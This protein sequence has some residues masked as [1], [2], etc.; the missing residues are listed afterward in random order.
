MKKTLIAAAILSGFAG[1][2]MAQNVTI[3]GI[4]DASVVRID[5]GTDS[6]IRLDSGRNAAS[7]L[8]FRGSED[9]GGGLKATFNLEHGFNVDNGSMAT[10]NT[11]F[12]R[13][14]WVGLEGGF[15]AV[16]AGR[17]DSPFRT[18]LN[19]IDPFANA[20]MAGSIDYFGYSTD[21]DPPDGGVTSLERVSNQVTYILPKDLG[22]LNGS[23]AYQFGENAAGSKPGS[24]W[25]GNVGYNVGG[26][27]LQLAYSRQNDTAGYVNDYLL[28]GAYDFGFLKLHA[29]YHQTKSEDGFATPEIDIQAFL[30]GVTVPLGEAMKLRGWYIDNSVDH[31]SGY[32]SQAFALS[33]TYALSKRTQFYTTFVM[34][35]NDTNSRMGALSTATPAGEKTNAIAFGI[36]HNF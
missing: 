34:T 3:Y 9:L 5:N 7:R 2:A 36:Q 16:R 24:S 14:A 6:L 13:W 32:D 10:A 30:V 28:G 35:D 22:G 31:A 4:V 11:F 29:G 26:L 19:V 27:A 25:A 15:G 20:G 12:S 33:L 17:Q 23:V 18:A 21:L 1:A 8:G